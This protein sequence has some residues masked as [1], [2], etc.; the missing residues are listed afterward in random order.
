MHP[1]VGVPVPA[2]RKQMIRSTTALP[3]GVPL[4]PEGALTFNED[5]NPQDEIDRL[6]DEL[7]W[8]GVDPDEAKKLLKTEILKTPDT[9]LGEDMAIA[10]IE[11]QEMEVSMKLF[12]PCAE[13]L[14]DVTVFDWPGH[15]NRWSA[16]S[17]RQKGRKNTR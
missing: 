3:M 9:S 8:E 12:D 17:Y 16:W 1:L 11:L 13:A 2:S 6:I 10:A 7:A 5:E 4:L 15:G 14:F